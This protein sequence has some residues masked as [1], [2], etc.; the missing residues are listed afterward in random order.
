MSASIAQTTTGSKSAKLDD[1]AAPD[2]RL[3]HLSPP[4]KLSYTETLHSALTEYQVPVKEWGILAW[5]VRVAFLGSDTPNSRETIRQLLQIRFL[6]MALLA[7]LVP[8]ET[9]TQKL[10]IYEPNLLQTLSALMSG[11]HG[12]DVSLAALTALEGISH[13]RN[14]LSEVLGVLGANANHGKLMFLCRRVVDGGTSPISF[15]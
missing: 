6:S 5:K 8:D 1:S 12:W 9:F 4:Y 10:L 7:Y 15:T 11:E 2:V 14:R 3:I 13:Y